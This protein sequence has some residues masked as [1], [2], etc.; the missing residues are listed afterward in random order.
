MSKP[1][2]PLRIKL[3]EDYEEAFTKA[4][5]YAETARRMGTFGYMP[6]LYY[7]LSDYYIDLSGELLERIKRMDDAKA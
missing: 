7:D 4:T 2:K 5:K 3:I 6:K 1:T